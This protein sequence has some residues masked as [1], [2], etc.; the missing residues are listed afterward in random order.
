MWNAPSRSEPKDLLAIGRP[1]PGKVPSLV[2]SQTLWR[3][4]LGSVGFEA[5][6]ID[7]RLPAF[8][9]VSQPFA[10]GRG[11]NKLDRAWTG[12]QSRGRAVRL[13]GRTSIFIHQTLESFWLGGNSP[14]T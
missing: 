5:G 2:Q 14:S 8:L 11:A 6:D 13:P 1:V 7:I 12:G 10:I 3:S 9:Q 4:Q